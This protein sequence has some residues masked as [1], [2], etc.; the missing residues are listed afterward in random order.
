MDDGLSHS[1]PLILPPLTRLRF[2]LRALDAIRLPAYS[3]SAWRGLL[4]HGLRRT[5]CVTR[6]P[7]CDGCLLLNHCVYASLFETHAPLGVDTKRFAASPRPYV[8]D[9]NPTAPREIAVGDSLEP[10]IVLI[11]GASQQVPYLIH[12]MQHAGDR[13]LGRDRGRFALGAL[14]R[15]SEPGSGDW[16]TVYDSAEGRYEPLE[17]PVAMAPPA[18]TSVR[19]TLVT[20]LRIKRHGHFLR[21]GDFSAV[22]FLL[23][24][25]ARLRLLAEHHGGDPAA[26]EWTRLHNG[27]E[28]IELCNCC[29]RWHDWTR[30]SSRQDTLMQMGG[31]LGSFELAGPDL[32]SFWQA[33]MY[34]Q[35]VHAGKGTT[36]GL[37]GY[38]LDPA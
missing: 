18:P 28:R 33:L 8:L 4:G 32:P 21:P 35:W 7:R 9:L 3:G 36:F 34:G 25:C 31:L 6:A 29:L 24:L 20:P 26:L 15:E 13:G 16:L 2:R 14:D 37:G 17:I 27:A 10:G 23:N 5:A 30:W 1:R 38:R 11:G 12:A 22:D 19:I